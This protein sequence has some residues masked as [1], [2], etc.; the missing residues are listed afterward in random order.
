MIDLRTHRVPNRS[1]L[2]LLI[3]LVAVTVINDGHFFITSAFFALIVGLFL[4]LFLGMGFG[5][6][7][8][9]MILCLFYIPATLVNAS[10]IIEGVTISAVLLIAITRIRGGK[11]RDPMAFAPCIFAG[12]LLCASLG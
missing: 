8:L 2:V 4:S 1:L 6:V 11:Y 5:D 10:L 12:T 7:K 9:L 3:S